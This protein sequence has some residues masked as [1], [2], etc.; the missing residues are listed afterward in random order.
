VDAVDEAEK[1]AVMFVHSLGKL[2]AMETGF[3]I[4]IEGLFRTLV[5]QVHGH[6]TH[7]NTA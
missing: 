7:A 1:S 3:D 6:D 5:E 4:D 2:Q